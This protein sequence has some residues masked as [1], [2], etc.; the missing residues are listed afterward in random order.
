M[1]NR[2]HLYFGDRERI[3]RAEEIRK[4]YEKKEVK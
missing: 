3:K 4:K 1:K 2:E